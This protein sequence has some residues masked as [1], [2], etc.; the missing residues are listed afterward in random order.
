MGYEDI[1]NKVALI[2]GGSGQNI[3]LKQLLFIYLPRSSTYFISLLT[4]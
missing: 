4:L 3:I 1:N 2:T